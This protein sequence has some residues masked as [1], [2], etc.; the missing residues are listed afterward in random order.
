MSNIEF[1]PDPLEE[2]RA[3]LVHQRVEH[4]LSQ[5][6]V[7]DLMG[8]TQSALSELERGNVRNPG[9]GT[10]ARWAK[11]LGVELQLVVTIK[12]RKALTLAPDGSDDR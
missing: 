12:V 3:Y 11:S 7:A 1:E 6:Q 2:L 10:L 4:A 5:T 8:T 9:I